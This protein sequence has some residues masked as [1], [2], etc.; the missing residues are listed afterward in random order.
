MAKFKAGDKVVRIGD[1]LDSFMVRGHEYTVIGSANGLI[2]VKNELGEQNDDE[3]FEA[4]FELVP[5]QK[6][7][8]MKFRVNSET[9]SRIIQE[10]LF[11]L[12]YSW[13]D[14]KN[15]Q[16]TDTCYLYT[17]PFGCIKFGTSE[18]HFNK[19]ENPQYAFEAVTTY[20]LV[21]LTPDL[22]EY[23]GKK[24]SK[25]EFEQALSKLNEY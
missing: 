3:Y 15:I 7:K 25:K 11:K 6:F 9:E 16:H 1:T 5:E 22:V 8:E 17:E 24:Y 21:K 4:N 19:H 13:I 18:N 2:I 20:N 23:N 10:E 12:G 14:G